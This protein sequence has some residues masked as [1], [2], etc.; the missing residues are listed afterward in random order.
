MLYMVFLANTQVS[1]SFW[2]F[3]KMGFCRI[4]FTI[5]ENYCYEQNFKNILKHYQTGEVLP[6]EKIQKIEDSKNF[7]EGYQTLRQLSFG[8]LDMSYHENVKVED[9]KPLKPKPSK[10]LK[11]ILLYQKQ[12]LAQVFHTFS[13]EDILRDII[14]TNGQKF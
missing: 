12:L 8:I 13:K 6:D 7:M 11:F 10:R 1:K 5:L 2:N 9:V 14:L 3:C 4:A